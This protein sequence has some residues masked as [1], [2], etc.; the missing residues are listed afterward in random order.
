[1]GT[2]SDH[3][4]VKLM[5][6]YLIAGLT[7]AC[8]HMYVL[9]H[10]VHMSMCQLLSVGVEIVIFCSKLVTVSHVASRG[11]NWLSTNAGINNL[12]STHAGVTASCLPMR[13]FWTAML[14]VP[15]VL[16]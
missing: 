8:L 4:S 3:Q 5:P 7:L 15:P 12:L 14:H 10:C 9:W 13:S 2:D 6:A 1:M 16:R 11:H